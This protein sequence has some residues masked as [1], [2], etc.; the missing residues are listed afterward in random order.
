MSKRSLD[1]YLKEYENPILNL[2]C[3]KS[4]PKEYYGIDIAEHEGVDAVCD[5]NEGIPLPDNS[6]V[7]INAIDFLEHLKPEN[8]IMIMEEI[9]RVL[10]PGGKLKALVPSTDGNNMGA[11]QDPTHYSFWNEKKF[12][13]FT[14]EGYFPISREIY[15]IQTWFKPLMLDTYYNEYNVTYVKAMLE[16]ELP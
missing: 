3:G 13:Y 11:F 9:Y 16:K 4:N 7:E 5:L 8:N 2:G 10:K 14:K 12:W 15:G 6:F 1:D